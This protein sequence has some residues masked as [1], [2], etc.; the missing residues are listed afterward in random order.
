[1]PLAE[2]G[3]EIK[4]VGNQSQFVQLKSK[5][6]SITFRLAGVP[7]YNAKHWKEDK[8][9][10]F[11]PKIMQQEEC[12]LCE[13]VDFTQDLED[14][15][16]K[17]AKVTFYFP[18]LNRETGQAQIFQTGLSV[19][20]AIEEYQRAG[21]DVYKIDWK[22]TRNEGENPAHYYGVVRLSEKK[23]TKEEEIEYEKA[24]AIDINAIIEGKQ[25]KNFEPP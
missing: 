17:K 10:V 4:G 12:K 8:T 6:D 24:T 2:F 11:C 7:G 23:L 1:M 21:E 25:S 5:G 15:R 16:N 9:W 18:I 22:V 19:R 13:E 14:K 20:A 3:S